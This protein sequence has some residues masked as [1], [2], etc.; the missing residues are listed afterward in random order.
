LRSV[1][2]SSFRDNAGFVFRDG[3]VVFRQVSEPYSQQ[4]RVLHETGLA[5]EL[6]GLGLLVRH[7]EVPFDFRENAGA[8]AV[9]RP[10]HVPFISYPYEWCFSQIKDAALCTLDIQKRALAKGMILKDASAF[11]IQFLNGRPILIDTLSFEIYEEGLPWIAYRQFCRHFLAPLALMAHV[12]PELGSLS[13]IHLDGV[14]LELASRALPF[15]TRLKPGLAINLHL[16]AKAEKGGA[17]GGPANARQVSRNGLLGLLESLEGAVQS[18]S[19]RPQGTVWADYYSD[20]NYSGKAM[21]EKARIVRG[22]LEA[23]PKKRMVWD[24]GANTGM[25]STIAA[26]SAEQVVAWD[27]DSGA[28]ERHYLQ[29]R[30]NRDERVLPLTQDLTNP[31]PGVGWGNEERDSFFG[32]AGADATLALALV[33]HLSIGNNVPLGRLAEF[34]SKISPHLIIEFVPKSDSQVQRLLAAKADV[35]PQYGEWGFEGAFAQHFRIREKTPIAGT[36]RT[37]YRMER[38]EAR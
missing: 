2:S 5:K 9:I 13:R 6:Q 17:A 36:E 21:D 35:F 18:L 23:I 19:W 11:N 16:H 8:I 38:A 10:D 15:G 37:L 33:H 30:A 4:W 1:E 14:P 32:R 26:E 22:M 31:S 24:L 34:F 12:H 29:R 25:F 7:E 28:V 27:M 3:E 20:T